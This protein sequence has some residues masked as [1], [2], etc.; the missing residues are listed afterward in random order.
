MIKQGDRRWS[1]RTEGE[2]VQ[3]LK[4]ELDQLDPAQRKLVK[5]LLKDMS[6]GNGEIY[7]A[8]A[9]SRWRWKPVDM[10]TF[11]DD[12][13]YLGDSCQTLYPQIREDLITL[14]D[15]HGY[16]E[17]ILTGSIGY[18]KTTFAS[19]AM[20]RMLYDIS[21]LR[22]PQL[23][24]GLS[25]GSEIV[26]ACMSKSLHL[27]RTVLK[28]AIDDK[29]K[30]S[31]Y[32]SEKFDPQFSRDYTRFPHNI[33]L[34]IGSCNSERVLGM[35]VVGGCMDE[36]NF[37]TAKGQV[38]SEGGGKKKTVANFDLAEKVYA[39]LVRRV[40]SRFLKASADLPGLMCLVSS[41]GTIGSFIDRR[42]AES[43]DDPEIF[44]RDYATWDVKPA[45]HFCGKTFAVLI[46]NS[47]LRSRMLAPGVSAAQRDLDE[48]CRLIDVPVEY[49]E[50][51]ARDLE[52]AIR[53]IAGI[54]T[55]AIS[56]FL[57]RHDAIY[58]R[59]N[60]A[61]HPFTD[62]E[63]TY[64]TSASFMWERLCTQK[65]VKLQGGFEEI[66]WVPKINPQKIRHVHIDPS[67]SGD[68]TG[69]AMGHIARWVEVVR[70]S[71]DGQEYNDL[72]PYI[73]ID[74]ML[75]INP[76]FGEQIF[77]PDVRRLV[78]ELQEHGFPLGGFTCDSYQSAETIQQMGRRGVKSS[79]LSVDRTTDPY[80]ALKGAIYED[81][82]EY[83]DYRPFLEEVKAL[84]YDRLRGKVDHP[85]AGTKDV[86][87]AVT[88]V[89]YGLAQSAPRIPL[90]PVASRAET[91]EEDV[92]WVM[93]K[94]K[95]P[96]DKNKPM[97]DKPNAYKDG[98][99]G[100]IIG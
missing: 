45:S 71:P 32:F 61:E 53:D 35:N 30:L 92:S 31:P 3:M 57:H 78:Y 97:P 12:P 42:L 44:A 87:D 65:T 25:P 2:K 94:R 23:A 28:S 90:A 54:S 55:H 86:S 69:L 27:S 26:V 75:R 13:Y 1:V 98:P 77:L 58:E 40:K 70:R 34:S 48:G 83:Y 47:S 15:G 82:I 66:H 14:M 99:L 5:A 89:V 41:A 52:N 6:E 4:E 39:G 67:L 10:A 16:R 43:K 81:R 29:L 22:S 80:D 72:A 21:C 9:E 79:V 74:F 88:G 59:I 76:P 93:D 84:E 50:D 51:F 60:T 85:Q 33:M 68:S 46:G 91:V 36:A 100:I 38:T 17:A 49:E 64:G 24:Y 63:Y 96:W 73:V 11:L 7:D 8:L 37:M 19:I 62:E 20:C 56:P 18:G 95:I